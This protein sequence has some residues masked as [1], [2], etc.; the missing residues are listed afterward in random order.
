MDTVKLDTDAQISIKKNTVTT[1]DAGNLTRFAEISN[2]E[3]FSINFSGKIND[4][5]FLI[6]KISSATSSLLTMLNESSLEYTDDNSKIAQFV[7]KKIVIEVTNN[8]YVL[9]TP[10]DWVIEDKFFIITLDN[11][12]FPVSIV[13]LN[14]TYSSNIPIFYLNLPFEKM[15]TNLFFQHT[16]FMD[17]KI[18]FGLES[19]NIKSIS[20]LDETIEQFDA[21]VRV[22]MVLSHIDQY[23]EYTNIVREYMEGRI[24]EFE[25]NLEKDLLLI[26]PIIQVLF[27]IFLILVNNDYKLRKPER[28]LLWQK[29]ASFEQ[30]LSFGIKTHL[31]WFTIISLVLWGIQMLI[32]KQIEYS[33][34]A[35]LATSFI[36]LIISTV[37][38]ISF[39]LLNYLRS[40]SERMEV[41]NL[42]EYKINNKNIVIIM[43]SISILI[44]LLNLLT[45]PVELSYIRI[46]I[47]LE[48]LN[49]IG[50]SSFFAIVIYLF[51]QKKQFLKK[52]F[53]P[54]KSPKDLWHDL[55]TSNSKHN[56]YIPF[57]FLLLLSSQFSY[58]MNEQNNNYF[59]LM[60]SEVE[61]FSDATLS[62]IDTNPIDLFHII[63]NSSMVIDFGMVFDF[64]Y[65]SMMLENGDTLQFTF[66]Y[67]L[68][69]MLNNYP[70]Q[71]NQFINGD[72]LIINELENQNHVLIDQEYTKLVQDDRLNCK[73]LNERDSLFEKID[74]DVVS[75]LR[76]VIAPS[77][78]PSIYLSNAT[79]NLADIHS[80]SGN[81]Y[82]NFDQSYSKEDT[83]T[84]I[85]G[86]QLLDQGVIQQK[87]R[88]QVFQKERM[89]I[90]NVVRIIILCI[91]PIVAIIFHA[92]NVDKEEKQLRL[93]WEKG[94]YRNLLVKNSLFMYF[95]HFVYDTI[96]FMICAFSIYLLNINKTE[97][98]NSGIYYP[99]LN[100]TIFL[101]TFLIHI[102][103]PYAVLFSIGLI[104]S[105]RMITYI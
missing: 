80:G 55:I 101:N 49:N 3:G 83:D 5:N 87:S 24:Q 57:V 96:I 65:K 10:P 1:Q 17:I 98:D 74:L 105:L 54:I 4:S 97:F 71:K 50:I 8:N 40:I 30:I 102:F 2:D 100:Y 99:S 76:Y 47:N 14:N 29:G 82:I 12:S 23:S 64:K 78:E 44:L 72:P 95:I 48:F 35:L 45:L 77:S 81:L 91:I 46:L 52:Y 33:Y 15:V 21:K 88:V 61:F 13:K 75:A 92:V 90:S 53:R 18:D 84:F 86:I 43:I 19:T 73:I 67:N 28:E 27:V 66:I 41:K 59:D 9:L 85:E 16:Q 51:I 32:I 79:I 37:Y 69:F 56:L 36:F 39:I 103:L 68:I 94:I 26:I 34:S 31:V 60:D 25:V 89:E 38:I 22:G 70:F 63:K 104:L 6:S 20:D 58:V 7:D 93:L 62:F 11:I 42:K